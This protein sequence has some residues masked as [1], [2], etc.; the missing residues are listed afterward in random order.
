MAEHSAD[1]FLGMSRHHAEA[2]AGAL[3]WAFRDISAGGWFT[4]DLRRDRINVWFDETDDRVV[5]AEIF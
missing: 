3:G 1:E 2:W 4:D 5:R